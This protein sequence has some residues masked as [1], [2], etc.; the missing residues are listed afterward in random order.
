MKIKTLLSFSFLC[1]LLTL[2]TALI[3]QRP[4]TLYVDANYTGGSSDGSSSAPFTTI[5]AALDYRGNTLGISGMVSDERILVKNGTYAP[6][7]TEMIFF[8]SKIQI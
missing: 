2:S 6:D 1:S 8:R 5:R 4:T 3:A 7:S